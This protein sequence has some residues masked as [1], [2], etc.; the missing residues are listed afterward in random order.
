[1]PPAVAAALPGRAALAAP[2]DLLMAWPRP[3]QWMAGLLLVLAA[4]L[5][6]GHTL[7][8]LPW[9]TRPTELECGLDYRVDLNR[10][11]RAE[12]VQLPGVGD[13]LARR[14]EDHRRARGGFRKVDDLLGV[15]GVGPVTLARL[16]PWVWVEAEEANGDD[17]P[18]Q[19]AP[20]PKPVPKKRAAAPAPKAD[21]RRAVGKKEASLTGKINVNRA[22][23][24][25]LQKLPRI[26][27]KLAQRIVDERG[28]GPFRS[29]DDLRRVAGIGPKTVEQ[30]RPY[31]TLKEAD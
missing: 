25:E 26:G 7:A 14:I 31:I 4:G 29:A 8:S 12:L 27:P 3:A 18:P 20:E 10:A 28:K 22:S 15:P 23:A 17:G 2:P 5:L 9:G 19:A 1:M 24:A 30:L 13:G 6:A 16:R 11:G 21:Q